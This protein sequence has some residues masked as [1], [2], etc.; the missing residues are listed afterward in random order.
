MVRDLYKE[1]CG[2]MLDAMDQ[3]FPSTASWTRP[4]GGMFIWVT[5]PEHIDGTEL[6]ARAIERNVAFVPGAPFYAGAE[7][8]KNTLRL[9]FVT[10]AEQRIREGIAILGQ[11]IKES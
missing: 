2:Y 5:L 7:A 3:H 4:E 1:Q 9:S 10:V 6:L 8:R 11:L